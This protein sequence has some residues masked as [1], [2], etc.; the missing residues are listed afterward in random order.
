MAVN[1]AFRLRSGRLIVLILTSGSLRVPVLVIGPGRQ[2]WAGKA[3]A[4]SPFHGHS[5]DQDHSAYQGYIRV[6]TYVHPKK[7]PARG[8]RPKPQSSERVVIAIEN[9]QLAFGRQQLADGVVLLPRLRR[10]NARPVVRTA[11]SAFNGPF[12]C[13]SLSPGLLGRRDCSHAATR[14]KVDA[15]HPA[16]IPAPSLSCR[17]NIGEM[18][19]KV[20]IKCAIA[21]CHRRLRM[22]LAEREKLRRVDGRITPRR[23]SYARPT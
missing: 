23:A 11:F 6:L 7:T 21:G 14:I 3:K 13:G 2:G 4:L 9:I 8:R 10:L 16:R 20:Q 1:F 5:A 22:T 17:C 18:P 12:R 19:R 15:E